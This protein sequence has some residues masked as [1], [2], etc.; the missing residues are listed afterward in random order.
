MDSLSQL[1]EA[2]ILRILSLL[3]AKDVVAT[4]VLSKRWQ[5][6]WTLVPKLIYDDSYQNI[7]YGRFSQFVDR[8]LLLHEAP[9][10]ETLHFKLAQK[11]G[12]VDI[13]LWTRT[14]VKR[15][16]REL[17]IEIDCSSSTTPVILPRSLYTS[18]AMLLTLKLNKVT[19]IDV[20]SSVS[21]PSLKTLSLS[22][23]N[24]PDDEFVKMLLSNCPVLEALDVE[25][26]TDDNVTIF[27]VIVPSLKS[28]FLRQSPFNVKDDARGFVIDAPSLECFDIVDHRGG[29]CVFE[30]NMPK[31]VI[32][33]VDV[34]YSHPGKILSSITSVKHLFLCLQISK[35]TIC[36]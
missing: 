26:I 16:V 8:S 32:A 35:V 2:L 7:E 29:F 36:C 1:P 21:F 25:R 3:P 33:N 24:Y 31:I 12:A 5:S 10:V 34:L 13:G 30:E 23:V 19:L 15:C 22:S 11:S 17:I 14:A 27:T 4:M 18:C 9:V 20:S 6:I 28:L